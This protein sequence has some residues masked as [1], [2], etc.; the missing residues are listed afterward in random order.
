MKNRYEV[1]F[2]ELKQKWFVLDKQT[3]TLVAGTDTDLKEV[4]EWNAEK[5]N[6]DSA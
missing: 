5:Y 4:A 6:K 3:D 1:Y 2:Y